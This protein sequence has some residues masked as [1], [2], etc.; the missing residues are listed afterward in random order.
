MGLE[1]NEKDVEELIADHKDNLTTADLQE[2]LNE[3]QKTLSEEH[4]SHS[5]EEEMEEVLP[6]EKI[7]DVLS[8]WNEVQE[9]VVRHHSNKTVAARTV[10][11]MNENVMFQFRKVLQNRRRQVTLERYLVR[12][13]EKA[14][15]SATAKRARKERSPEAELSTVPSKH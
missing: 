7:R 9:F 10:D 1:V 8:K 2:L 5:E 3:Q 14:E 4:S 6:S 12:T 11:L 15:K 13:Q